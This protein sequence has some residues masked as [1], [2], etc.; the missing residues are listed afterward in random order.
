MF[1][2]GGDVAADPEPRFRSGLRAVTATDL[3][4]GLGRADVTLGLVVGERHRQVPGE[5]Q[6]LVVAV[7]EAL[8]EIA[9]LRLTAPGDAAMF[10]KPDQQRVAPRVEQRIGDLRWNRR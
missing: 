10:G 4:L 3:H 6:H 8:E 1:A 9:G 7:A 2:D 5:Q